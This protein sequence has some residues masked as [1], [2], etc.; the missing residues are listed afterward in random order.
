MKRILTSVLLLSSIALAGPAMAQYG[1]AGGSVGQSRYNDEC[2]S[3][4]DKTDIGF[5][6]F[7]GY[8]FTP[9][10]GI[11]AHYVNL[12]KLTFSENVPPFGT[13]NGEVKASGFGASVVGLLPIDRFELFG[14]LGFTY[15]DTKIS[16]SIAN[17]GAASDDDKAANF[18]FGLGAAY[19]INKQLSARLEW[20]RFRAEY[21][22]EKEDVDLISIGVSYRF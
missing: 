13:V 22:D 16:G 14:K 15:M 5:K 20:E 18:S 9:N 4:C 12:G 7:G 6:L 3:S 19:N 10:V 1:Y 2:G 17:L 21:Q 11:E 8:M